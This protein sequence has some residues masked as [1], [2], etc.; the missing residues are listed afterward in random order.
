MRVLQIL[1]LGVLGVAGLTGCQRTD[2]VRTTEADV[3]IQPRQAAAG[4]H[5]GRAVVWGGTLVAVQNLKDRTR[6]EVLAFPL[7]S[8]GYP[9]ADDPST[10]RF[11]ADHFG[12][13]DPA[14]YA[15]GRRVTVRGN[16]RGVETGSVGDAPYRYPAVEVVDVRLWRADAPGDSFWSPRFHIG[17][18]VYKGF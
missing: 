18:G 10:G 8:D 11:M 16:I 17:I 7:D 3:T 4:G 1:L 5:A 15:P 14:D 2:P 6:L 9:E 13:L 12:F